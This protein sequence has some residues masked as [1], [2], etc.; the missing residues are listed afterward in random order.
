MQQA[1]VIVSDYSTLMVEALADN[2][3]PEAGAVYAALDIPF[4]VLV[5]Q[6]AAACQS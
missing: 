6:M 1:G 2:A 5:G 3:A 4:A